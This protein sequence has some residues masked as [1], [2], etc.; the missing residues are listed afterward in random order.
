MKIRVDFRSTH[1]DS[2]TVKSGYWAN[3]RGG[4]AACGIVRFST[5]R[6]GE[7]GRLPMEWSKCLIPLVTSKKVKVL[8][9]CVAAPASLSMM[10]EIML[11]ISF[12]I[13]RSIFTEDGN[14]S[15]KLDSPSNIDTTI[16]PLLTLFKLLKKSPFQKAEFTPEE[17]DTRKRALTLEVCLLDQYPLFVLLFTFSCL[18]YYCFK[19]CICFGTIRLIL[20]SLV[21]TSQPILS[22]Y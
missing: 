10:Q 11:Y 22:S 1:E 5:K 16:Y 4:S 14:C 17:L 6:S 20:I 15:W 2:E 8:G 21:V 12:Y 13:H 18:G 3:S 7:I 9:R 19:I